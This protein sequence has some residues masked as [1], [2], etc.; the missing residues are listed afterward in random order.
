LHPNC[1]EL[2]PKNWGIYL[3]PLTIITLFI[4]V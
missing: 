3:K 1:H 2:S 4:I